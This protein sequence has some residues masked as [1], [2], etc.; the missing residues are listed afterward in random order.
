[1]YSLSASCHAR[2][3]KPVAFL[4][5]VLSSTEKHN[6]IPAVWESEVYNQVG[7]IKGPV[8]TN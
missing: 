1:M 3:A 7:E 2:M 8:Y 5:F 6:N 4:N